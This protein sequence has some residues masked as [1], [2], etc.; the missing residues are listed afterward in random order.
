[1]GGQIVAMG[2]GGFMLDPRSLLAHLPLECAV[3]SPPRVCVPPTPAPDSDRWVVA[4]FE[5]FAARD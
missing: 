3:A 1:M 5:A 4:L 2:G